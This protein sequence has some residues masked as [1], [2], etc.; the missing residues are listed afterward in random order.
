MVG[1]VTLVVATAGDEGRGDEVSGVEVGWGADVVTG[2]TTLGDGPSVAAP[3]PS[4]LQAGTT[5]RIAPMNKLARLIRAG[6]PAPGPT[7]PRFHRTAGRVEAERSP[8][9]VSS[10]ISP[11]L[12]DALGAHTYNPQVATHNSQPKSL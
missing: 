11:I 1:P 5:R 4:S 12:W 9:S 10:A 2:A 7:W 8:G 6:Y 3:D